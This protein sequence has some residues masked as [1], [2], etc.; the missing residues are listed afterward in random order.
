MPAT[1]PGNGLPGVY[2]CASEGVWRHT[3][4]WSSVLRMLP[5][6]VDESGFIER[7]I[8]DSDELHWTEHDHELFNLLD[9]V[10]P[11]LGDEDVELEVIQRAE[12]REPQVVL[13]PQP[14]PEP[15]VVSKPA[16][17]ARP[18][19]RFLPESVEGDEQ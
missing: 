19:L 6:Q 11:K 1:G 15:A 7:L 2:T 16:P 10:D 8:P 17:K 13:E 3:I 4:K 9:A 12:A 5:A 14:A 18:K